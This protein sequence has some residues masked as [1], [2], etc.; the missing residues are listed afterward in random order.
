[1]DRRTTL[2]RPDTILILYRSQMNRHDANVAF[3]VDIGG[4][5][6]KGARVDLN[7]GELVTERYRIET[8]RPAKPKAVCNVVRDVVKKQE[9]DG[10]IGCTFPAVVKNG[11]V[12]A[13]ANMHD[14]W[15]DVNG[16]EL[17]SDRLGH[18]VHMMNDGDAA[19]IAEM[20]FGAGREYR[21]S[22]VVLMLTFGTGIGSAI[23]VNGHLLPNSEFGQ[24]E[25][26]G[27]KAERRAAAQFRENKEISWKKWIEQVQAYL[28][29]VELLLSPDL[30]IFGGGIS[31]KSDKF[32]GEL[33][34]KC[35][36][37]PA[38]LQNNAGI[39]GAAYAG[40]LRGRGAEIGIGESKPNNGVA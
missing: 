5:G 9:W 7:S 21:D 10:P 13:A 38:A 1:M 26:N 37:V 22:G 36:L 20:Q 24:V 12:Q 40:A 28:S 39:V 16:E 35:L 25:L 29:Y 18:A 3:G 33:K 32:L 19:G 15:V 30:I 14:A 6:I 34:T 11:V 17:I 27:E 31:K 23:F 2:Q 8:P 4:S